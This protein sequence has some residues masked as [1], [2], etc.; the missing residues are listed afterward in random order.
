M[1]IFLV[2]VC[3]DVLEEFCF[4]NDVYGFLQNVFVIGKWLGEIGDEIDVKYKDQFKDMIDL[5]SFIFVMVY[6]IF[7]VVV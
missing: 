5:L 7:V 3:L 1:N 2:I 6:E 4:C